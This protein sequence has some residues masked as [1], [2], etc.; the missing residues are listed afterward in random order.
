MSAM[1][2]LK[3]LF[4]SKLR[5]KVLS[6]FFLRPGETFHVRRLAEILDEPVGTLSRELLNLE[7]AGLLL[8]KKVGNQ[9]HFSLCEDSPIHNELRGIFLKTTAAGDAIRDAVSGI[10]GVEIVFLYG[11]FAAGEAGP[12]SDVDVMV[13][14]KASGREL[15]AAFS[16]VE[17]RIGREVNYTA[18]TREE[19]AGRIRRE[20]DF[21]HEVFTGPRILLVGDHDDRLFKT[22]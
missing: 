15:A 16:L 18:Y 9:K 12:N 20:G 4:S 21:V 8:S 6:H 2:L 19:A 5:I 1:A 3:R 7:K 11:S 10:P 13:V 17:R 22:A 14:G